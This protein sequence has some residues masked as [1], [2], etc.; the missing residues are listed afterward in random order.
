[1]ALWYSADSESPNRRGTIY[2]VSIAD[3]PVTTGLIGNLGEI[4]LEALSPSVNDA[5]VVSLVDGDGI[6]NPG[7][8]NITEG[9][10]V[11]FDGADWALIVSPSNVSDAVPDFSVHASL[12]T[13][14]PL[15]APYID[16]VDDGQFVAFDGTSLTGT[17]ITTP[18]LVNN[19]I[20][21]LTPTNGATTYYLDHNSLADGLVS[22]NR[23]SLILDVV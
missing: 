11:E 16:G 3:V 22:G 4:A 5:Y 13:S 17:V 9:D 8:L 15:I 18:S 14:A 10:I 2:A 1:M 6:L 7:S 21:G 12:S 20:Q 19:E 23:L